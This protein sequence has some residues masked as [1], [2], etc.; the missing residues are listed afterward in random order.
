MFFNWNFLKKFVIFTEK[1]LCWSLFLIKLHAFILATLLKT[2]SN[3]G[4]FL[5]ILQT[6]ITSISKNIR[7]RLVLIVVIYC[8]ENWIKLFR[9]RIGLLFLLKHKIYYTYSHSCSF[10]L[11]LAVIRCH[12]LPFFVTCCRLLSFVVTCCTTRCHSLYH[13][14]S[15]VLP[16][17][18]IRCRSI[19]FDVPLVVIRC[20][21]LSFYVTRCITRLSFYKQSLFYN[22]LL[23]TS[24]IIQAQKK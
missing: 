24:F 13:S 1:H 9:K 2:D 22:F 17:D 18:V 11:S 8:I 15:F 4:V 19:S 23:F 12:S 5:W 20:H 7:V 3:T 14:L 6:L 10:V 16:L 21:S